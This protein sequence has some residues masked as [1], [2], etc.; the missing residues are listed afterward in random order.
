MPAIRSVLLAI[1]ASLVGS[2]AWA[3]NVGDAA[4]DFMFDKT[5]N[6]PPD[7]SRLSDYRGSV[8]L[9]ECW[10]SWCGPCRQIVPHMNEIAAV[11]IPQGLSIVS[12]SDE[13]SSTIKRF[14]RDQGIEYPV[15]EA[16]HVLDMFGRDTIPS[17]WLIDVNGIVMWEGHP[18][19]LNSA[20]I[21]SAL[22]RG[23]GAAVPGTPTPAGIEESNWWIWLIV[24]PALLFAGAMG[25]FVWSTRDRS[26]QPAMTSLYQAPPGGPQYP[27]QS[28]AAPPGYPPPQPQNPAPPPPA[29]YG[30]YA[31]APP[32]PSQVPTRQGTSRYGPDGLS[33]SPGAYAKPAPPPLEERPFI[34]QDPGQDGG[35]IPPY[36]TN[37]N[38]PGNPYR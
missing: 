21:A 13:D 7:K 38:R 10:A 17:A 14:M 35:Q 4:P 8:V 32:L 5:W 2:A 11:Y 3:I 18:G 24:V 37:Q 6:A 1:I 36:D 27:P 25:W 23:R 29:Q 16:K 26:V 20:D 9:L 28:P 34:G 33:E 15:A 19:E 31:G 12:V 30:G 22:E